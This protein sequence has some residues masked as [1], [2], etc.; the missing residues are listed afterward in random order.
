MDAVYFYGVTCTH[1]DKV[2]PLLLDLETRYPELNLT[3]LE[4]YTN[5]ENRERFLS[6]SHHYGISN[7][8]V[9]LVFIGDRALEG[10]QVITSQFE[11]AILEEKKRLA[12]LNNTAQP[13]TGFFDPGAAAES[14][15]ISLPLVF[16]AALVDSTNPCGLA[17]LVFLLITMAAAGSRKRIL[18]AGT[19]YI[20]AMFLFHL[21]VG[22]GLFSVIAA[23]G[24]S[25]VFSIIG[26]LIALLFGLINL[27]DLLRNKETFSLS[28]SA[29]HK[30]F[31]GDYARKATLPAA[32]ILGILAGILGFTCT[33]GIYISILGL[34]G[35][36]MSVMTGIVWLV[37]Y[38]L[39]FVLPLIL[40]TLLVAYGISPERADRLRTENKRALRA[41]ISL[42]LIALGLIILFDW[43]G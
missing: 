33:G 35:R 25:R 19:A 18:L 24:L 10:D 4:V 11:G 6:M 21:F 20:S 8:G 43:M 32:F 7:P 1:C 13:W 28:I 41:L 14:S 16:G 36:D 17:V 27:A 23:S 3:R 12:S 38:N 34:M 42:I 15:R 29:S 9:P 30:G 2:K 39:I 40:I 22:I 26:G 5:A 37:F 31:L